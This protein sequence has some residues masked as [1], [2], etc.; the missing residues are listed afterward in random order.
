MGFDGQQIVGVRFPKLTSCR[1][2]VTL[3]TVASTST[4]QLQWARIRTA[5]VCTRSPAQSAGI[6]SA[7]ELFIV[8]RNLYC[9]SLALD[10][11][12]KLAVIGA[13]A[14]GVLAD[15]GRQLTPSML[16]NAKNELRRSA[17]SER[18]S[19]RLSVIGDSLYRPGSAAPAFNLTILSS[20]G[21][22][23]IAFD[24]NSTS[25]TPS[26]HPLFPLIFFGFN[27]LDPFPNVMVTDGPNSIDV[28]LQQASP[29][30]T[31][32]FMSYAT[33]PNTALG[34]VQAMQVRDLCTPIRWPRIGQRLDNAM[35]LQ[36][37][38][39]DVTP[40]SKW[41]TPDVESMPCSD[42]LTCR[43]Y[44]SS[45]LD[46]QA[47]FFARMYALG[48]T[49]AQAQAWYNRLLFVTQSIP[50]LASDPVNGWIPAMLSNWT[51][52]VEQVVVY[53]PQSPASDSSSAAAAPANI[54]VNRIDS[55][56]AWLPWPIAGSNSTLVWGGD[57]CNPAAYG[58]TGGNF[59]G[60]VALVQFAGHNSGCDWTAVVG[61]AQTA[62]ASGVVVIQAQTTALADMNCFSPDE[63]AQPLGISASLITYTDGQS[64]LAAM[65]SYAPA[66]MSL[67]MSFNELEAPGYFFG[68]DD[69][70]VPQL[71]EL[72][73]AKIPT[74]MVLGWQGLWQEHMADL[75]YNLTR[76]ALVVPVFNHT[77][78]QG[79]PGAST[80]VTLPLPPGE[81]MSQYGVFE[82]DMQ[83]GCPTPWDTSC[84]IWDRTVQLSICCE[85]TEGT[86]LCGA[87]LGRWISPFR[88]GIGRW[89]TDITPL[90][91]LLAGQTCNLTMYTDAWAMPWYPSLSL[92]FR[93][94][95]N[96]SSA[97]EGSSTESIVVS[98][99]TGTAAPA[100]PRISDPS[101]ALAAAGLTPRLSVP[102]YSPGAT[103]DQNF[104]SH[105]PPL[106][107][108]TPVW[109][110]AALIAAVITGHGSDNNGC[111]EFCTTEHTFTFN[112]NNH[113]VVYGGAGT[114]WGCADKT[115]LG[116]EPNE[117]GT[118][119]YGRDG[120]CDGMEVRPWLIDVT[121]ELLPPSQS[122]SSVAPAAGGDYS[123]RGSSEPFAEADGVASA[124]GSSLSAA[125]N[126]VTYMGYYNWMPPSP[127]ASPGY[128]IHHSYITFYA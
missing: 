112:G 72:G 60:S 38:I 85:G 68:I 14:G 24:G 51:S 94:A 1:L 50:S 57:A 18:S 58:V 6:R 30:V 15:S 19:R 23:Y 55:H 90:F 59:N 118:W 81:L 116:G 114:E 54:T 17:A 108:P 76:P 101:L 26:G 47:I 91:P 98:T 127:T 4:P 79:T 53:P 122:I 77:L 11:M 39:P 2:F 63:C 20:G 111:G 13:L 22:G 8:I 28:F 44:G 61:A 25:P 93:N 124:A 105:F 46:L 107:I 103:F 45:L 16:S 56:Y 10:K 95:T 66:T 9:G 71:F 80:N 3:P 64:L 33:D 7:T 106:S 120:W 42:P 36:L 115:R 128:I 21:P 84:A 104:S 27:S 65:Q 83:L 43:A 35:S 62:G 49:M 88:R 102:L 82:L 78:M 86:P 110:K 125:N 48:W 92:R 67:P 5:S 109:A 29:N 117:H 12:L 52:P 89:L 74:M 100:S 113:T 69:Q 87:E 126:T 119:F 75:R 32:A 99:A 123:L 96:T 121:S 73:W 41:A 70:P 34:D 97:L 37:R 31:Y 40:P